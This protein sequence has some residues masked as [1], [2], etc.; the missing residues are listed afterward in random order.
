M[1]MPREMWQRVIPSDAG[2]GYVAASLGRYRSGRGMVPNY[3]LIATSG[4]FE[5]IWPREGFS[6]EVLVRF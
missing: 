2:E 6:E 4:P 5:V 1:R 3:R